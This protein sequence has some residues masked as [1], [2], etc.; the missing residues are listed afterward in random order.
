M[1]NVRFSFFV[2]L[3]YSATRVN[4]QNDSLHSVV[5]AGTANMEVRFGPNCMGN[6][7]ASLSCPHIIIG[8]RLSFLNGW[9]VT[10][11]FEYEHVYDD[12]EWSNHFNSEFCTNVLYVAKN[13]TDALNVKAGIVDI[14]VG[15]ISSG[16]P[17][18]TIDD[19]DNEADIIPMMWHEAGISLFGSYKRFVYSLTATSY[20]NTLELL[21]VA[22][23]TDYHFGDSLRVGLSGY[24]G[25]RCHGMI[26]REMSEKYSSSCLKYLTMD[27]DYSV[28]GLLL[29]GSMVYCSDGNCKS[30]G[31]E[32]G[33]D[34]MSHADYNKYHSRII[35]FLRYDCVSGKYLTNKQ[36]YT[37]GINVVPIPNLIFK[38][39]YGIR[40]YA[41][42]ATSSQLAF[43]LAYTVNF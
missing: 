21:G 28:N 11:Q 41:S 26:G 23:R 20:V 7:Q 43:S 33:Y 24:I 6:E 10:S 4:G 18:L 1:S 40:N 31:C 30:L 36:K 2:I 35:P 32:L 34:L 8:G 29:D 3:L 37:I 25:K 38:A 13:F 12:H 5:F 42:S 14:P 17:A 15:L 16:G 27:M 22:A 19:P 39:E 9:S